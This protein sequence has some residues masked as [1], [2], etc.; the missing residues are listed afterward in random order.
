MGL[1]KAFRRQ[2]QMGIRGSLSIEP[3][4]TGPAPMLKTIEKETALWSSL[5]KELDISLD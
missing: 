4:N 3:V 2:R 5:V 1:T